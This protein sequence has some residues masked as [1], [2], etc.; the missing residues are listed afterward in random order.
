MSKHCV[1]IVDDVESNR[2][3]LKMILED[4]YAILESASGSECLQIIQDKQPDLV[5]LDI[6]MPGMSGY[7]VCTAL[8]KTKASLT[9]PVIFVSAL[10]NLEERLAGFE[11]GANDYITKPI[12]PERVLERVQY[13]IDHQAEAN[14]VKADATSAMQVAMEAMTSS[15]ELGQIIEF[16]KNTQNTTSLEGI[17]KQFC[18]IAQNFG[19]T[20]NLLIHA[21]PPMLI[22][23]SPESM[24][25]RVLNKFKNSKEY[26]VSIGVRTLLNSQDMS[27]L[28]SNMPIDDESRYG[29]LKDHLAV[30]S[31]I[32][33][34]RLQNIKTDL[35]SKSQRKELLNNV[36]KMTE[37]NVHNFTHKLNEHDQKSRQIMLDMITELEAKLFTLGLDEDQEQQLMMLAYDASERLD[38]MKKD[39]KELEGE[40]SIILEVLYKIFANDP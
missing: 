39:T 1:L 26:I 2:M 4:D 22:N 37:D 23:C 13:F 10:D 8:R 5:L 24:E 15:S 11:V 27:I 36:I 17:G 32:C 20:A 12:N 18:S 25:A 7:E 35:L 34:G 31:R 38:T 28:I 30:L 29:R 40:L 21:N 16:V 6:N 19:L 14:K 33:E 9:L 3:L